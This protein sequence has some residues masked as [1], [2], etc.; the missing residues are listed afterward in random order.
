[1]RVKLFLKMKEKR[2]LT[3]STKRTKNF[4]QLPQIWVDSS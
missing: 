3:V 4:Q 1:M 2:K